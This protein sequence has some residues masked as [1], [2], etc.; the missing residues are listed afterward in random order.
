VVGR[1]G[2]GGIW[3]G[4]RVSSSD[5]RLRPVRLSD[6]QV[7]RSAH[8][9]LGVEAFDF[10]IGLRPDTSWSAYVE[11]LDLVRRA[12][13]LPEPWVPATFLLAFVG[14]DLVGRTSIRHGLNDFLLAAGGHIGYAVLSQFRRR[15][16]ATEILTQSLVVAR[17]YDVGSVLVTCDEDNGASS[18][19]I[20]RCG[21]VLENIVDNPEG[22]P[23]KRRY[24]I[25]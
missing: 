2:G 22:G 17:S 16:F 23:R 14:D 6:E 25:D 15:G 21:G 20:T 8:R 3:H 11:Q 12:T 24:W 4:A 9:E 7:V 5:L 19:V 18:R 10:A 13:H 1:I